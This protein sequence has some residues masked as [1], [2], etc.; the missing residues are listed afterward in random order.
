MQ[1]DDMGASLA[2]ACLSRMPALL[3]PLY[4]ATL[5]QV[6]RKQ[7]R[8]TRESLLSVRTKFIFQNRMCHIRNHS[9]KL[10]AGIS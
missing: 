2:L 3:L 1:T 4:S 6:G 9:M 8:N 7:K 5:E 10:L